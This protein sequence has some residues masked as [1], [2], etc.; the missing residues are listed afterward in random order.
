M[1][2]DPWTAA[3]RRM[4]A[5]QIAGRK[6]AAPA[7]LTAMEQ[8]PRHEFIPGH[9]PADA[10]GDHPVPIGHGQTV[11]Q[12]YIVAFMTAALELPAG[13]RVLEVGT[14][15]GYQAAVLV[16]AGCQVWSVE[17]IPA[18]AQRA[19]LDL[20]RLGIAG[21]R[22]REGD[23]HGGW[24]E[25]APFDGIIVAAAP[26]EIPPALFDQLGPNGRL[27]IP[28]GRGSQ[29]LWRYRRTPDGIASEELMAVRFVPMTGQS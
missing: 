16:A 1:E 6:V 26:A 25:E 2:D 24:P 21:V 4:V 10:Y 3:R 9:S 23:G 18:L 8:V 12:P 28:V 20:R 22:V 14:G 15:C 17:I 13:A 29:S 11:S 19:E 5:Q 27:I 7:V